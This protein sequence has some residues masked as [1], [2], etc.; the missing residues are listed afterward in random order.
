[1]SLTEGDCGCRSGERPLPRLE[2]NLKPFR[3]LTRSQK[4][5]KRPESNGGKILSLMEGL[6]A[7]DALT[8]RADTTIR[9][10]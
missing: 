5:R 3:N 2:G 4:V 6:G 1:M 9:G 7:Q 8:P 10:Q